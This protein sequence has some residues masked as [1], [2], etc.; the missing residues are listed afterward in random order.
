MRHAVADG[1]RYA[2]N[3]GNHRDDIDDMAKRSGQGLAKERRQS[4]PDGQRKTA[5]IAEEGKGK[6]DKRV[7]GPGR[8]SPVQER[9]FEGG[10]D[11]VMGLGKDGAADHIG[12]VAEMEDR[13]GR[14]I[15]QHADADSRAEHH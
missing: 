2:E 13:F 7:A 9:P 3:G 10:P 14:G 11:I 12:I 4:R 8:E 6:P 5:R 1:D 15:G